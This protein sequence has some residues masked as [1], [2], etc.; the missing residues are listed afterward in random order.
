MPRKR[1]KRLTKQPDIPDPSSASAVVAV[2]VGTGLA[3]ARNTSV[4][5]VGER[6]TGLVGD[7]SYVDIY[8]SICFHSYMGLR[9]EMEMW[10]FARS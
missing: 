1:G 8:V 2:L 7:H 4:A 9:V 6:R 10:V 5:G 3:E